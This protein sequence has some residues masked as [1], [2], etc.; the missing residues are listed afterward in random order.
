MRPPEPD[1]ERQDSGL[2]GP[3]SRLEEACASGDQRAAL[4]ALRDELA[5]ALVDGS[6]GTVAQ[7]A[8]QLRACITEIAALPRPEVDD[9]DDLR[10]RRAARRAE[11]A[12]GERSAGSG[13]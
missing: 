6:A 11:T 9:V 10:A 13:G 1:P 3:G 5:K 8:A 12:P 4:E 2:R 7:T